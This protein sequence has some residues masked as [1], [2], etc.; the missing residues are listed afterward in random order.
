MTFPEILE[1]VNQLSAD[2]FAE[3]QRYMYQ[4]QAD[5]SDVDVLTTFA[6]LSDGELWNIVNQPFNLIED[7]R[8][9]E[10]HETRELRALTDEEENEIEGLLNSLD[11]FILRRSMVMY[12]LQKRGV[13]VMG[14][15]K[16]QE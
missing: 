13:D 9:Q 2:E 3:L 6:K 10:L 5:K 8:L 14:K 15:L 12:L 1:A 16:E 11:K 7:A 4:K